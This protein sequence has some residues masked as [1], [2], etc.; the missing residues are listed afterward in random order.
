MHR[1]LAGVP[2]HIITVDDYLTARDAEAMRPVHQAL[3]LT[4]G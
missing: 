4:L 2:V 1:V 3:G